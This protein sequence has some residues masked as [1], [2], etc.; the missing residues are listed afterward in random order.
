[1]STPICLECGSPFMHEV[2]STTLN[3]FVWKCDD[4]CYVDGEEQE[5]PDAE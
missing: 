2:F 4:C 3:C 5:E 1:M